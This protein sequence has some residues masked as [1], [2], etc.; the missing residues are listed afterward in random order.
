[1]IKVIWRSIKSNIYKMYHSKLL[2]MHLLL[3]I[4]AAIAF[5]AYFAVTFKT[6]VENVKLYLQF[7]SILFPFMIAI[8][9]TMVY[10]ADLDAGGFQMF[11]MLPAKKWKGHLGNLT[12]LLLLGLLASLLAVLGFGL[13]YRGG[14]N[15][16]L[17]ILFYLKTTGILFGVNVVGYFIQYVLCYTFGKGVSLSL[18]FVELLLGP[19][20]YMRMGD[21]VW[22]W[23][24]CSYG[25]RMISYY[26]GINTSN[27]NPQD[28]FLDYIA[29][30]LGVGTKTI[31]GVTACTVILFYVWGNVWE[32]SRAP[33]E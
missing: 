23:I 11:R 1:M 28:Y 9:T 32:G 20:M 29:N 27:R 30:E 21:F 8:V 22:K 5:N 31:V 15:F 3:P 14:G 16:S 24:P 10:E 33:R 25:I 19:L 26:F 12:A 4:S 17:P 2:W 6:E 7:I 13:F 18:G